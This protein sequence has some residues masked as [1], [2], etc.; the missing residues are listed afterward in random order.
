MQKWGSFETQQRC[1]LA[2]VS[3]NE[4]YLPE[5]AKDRRL[6]ELLNRRIILCQVDDCMHIPCLDQRL[7]RLALEGC[8]YK[9]AEPVEAFWAYRQLAHKCVGHV[10]LND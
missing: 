1:M 10:S 2:D 3:Q 8:R 5:G 4:S 6:K 9:P 7:Q